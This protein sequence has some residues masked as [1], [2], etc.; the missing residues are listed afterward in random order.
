[1]KTLPI[2]ASAAAALLSLSACDNK[3]IQVGDVPDPNREKVDAKPKVE[4]PPTIEASVTFR[5]QPGN[6][7]L[8]VEFFKGHKL[9][10]LRTTKDGLPIKLEA[11]AEGQPYVGADGS[12]VSGT[13]KA[14]TIVTGG[15]TSTCKA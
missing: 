11:P 10:L 7:L 9:A 12:R 14:A 15:K 1:M 4:L 13:A 2:I 8:Y 3:P 5:C 6:T